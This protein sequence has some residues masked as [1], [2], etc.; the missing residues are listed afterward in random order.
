M[1]GPATL[2]AQAPVPQASTQS[3]DVTAR[4]SQL[5]TETQSLRAE[6]QRLRD[7]PTRLPSTEAT[8]VSMATNAAS[9]T[10]VAGTASNGTVD[11]AAAG[12]PDYFTMDELR[13]E[14]K[15]FAWRKGDFSIVPYGIL[16]GNTVYSTEH[17]SPGSYTF[18]V[19][20]A[21]SQSGGQFVVDGRNTRLGTDVEGP[22]IPFFDYA[23]SGGK[24][25][26]DFQ[27]TVLT[28]E[29]KST[30]LLR[31][32]YVEVKDD[33]FR[34]LA[35]QTW[36]VISPLS[37][38]TILYSIGWEAGNMGYRRAQLR[39]EQYFKLSDTSM[40]TTQL[41]I[42]QDVFPDTS[43]TVIAETPSWPIIE[44]RVAWTLGERK[45]G[46]NPIVIGL[47]GHIG[48]DEFDNTLAKDH[49]RR[50]WSGNLDIR[51]P[52]TER[53]GVE[54][55]CY[56]GENLS[57]FLG[58]IGQGI[59]PTTFNTIRSTGGWFEVW[60]DWT[61]SLHSHIGYSVDNPND[62]DLS[63]VGEKTYNQFYFGN[64]MYDFTKDFMVGLEV[65]SWK[66]LYVGE[67]PGNA[68]RTEFVAKYSF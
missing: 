60:Y 36:D 34:L 21:S 61:P 59:D 12:S 23:K 22:E 28:T 45:P 10:T 52:L 54:G 40:I 24:V 13:G 18:F 16:W 57:A 30:V 27:N 47:S 35:G 64:V 43:T 44:G 39:D 63:T 17:T 6:V 32:A 25:E 49:N 1:C 55:E 29:N 56:T 15:K 8:P 20:S 41:S 9:S 68:V 67:L 66:T 2:F 33:D 31:H 38:D 19:T 4:L 11:P 50:T 46:C 5:E 3:E 62:H 7:N 26:I 58:G 65:S 42:N 14:M 48:D 53:L 37:P 51:V